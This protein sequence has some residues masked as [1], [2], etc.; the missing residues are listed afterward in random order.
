MS[1]RPLPR[2]VSELGDRAVFFDVDGDPVS[3]DAWGAVRWIGGKPE[4]A[5][6][7][8]AAR[9]VAISA[10]RF[11]ELVGE[12]SLDAPRNAGPVV[13]PVFGPGAWFVAVEGEPVSV[14]KGEVRVWRDGR[15]EPF[16]AESA[17]KGDDIDERMFRELVAA[18]SDGEPVDLTKLPLKQRTTLLGAAIVAGLRA[19]TS[20]DDDA[21]KS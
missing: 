8:S 20:E 15:P 11:R 16:S 21:P 3:F 12:R 17:I 9:G 6:A 2:D 4:R 18:Q 7:E 10:A 19:Q 5:S 14:S 1:E 13:L